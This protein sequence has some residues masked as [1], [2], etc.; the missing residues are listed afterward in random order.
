MLTKQLFKCAVCKVDIKNR[1][2]VDHNH[3]TGQVR[4]LLCDSC[5]LGIGAFREN[6][7]TIEKVIKYLKKWNINS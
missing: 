6:T 1:A 3:T 7:K 4:E 2:C 5:N